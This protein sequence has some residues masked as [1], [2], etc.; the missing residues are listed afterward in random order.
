V[1]FVEITFLVFYFPRPPHYST[2]KKKKPGAETALDTQGIPVALLGRRAIL[3]TTGLSL[4]NERMLR[5]IAR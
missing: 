5:F 4:T 3:H 1:K 2:I